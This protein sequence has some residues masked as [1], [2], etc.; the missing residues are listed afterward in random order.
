MVSKG[1]SV[2]QFTQRI[3]ADLKARLIGQ[4][5]LV[6]LGGE[7]IRTK[8]TASTQSIRFSLRTTDRTE[9]KRRQAIAVAFM[10]DL[11]DKLRAAKPV[12][13]T[14]QQVASLLGELHASWAREPD[15]SPQVTVTPA[16]RTIDTDHEHDPELIA[17]W[18]QLH[19]DLAARAATEPLFFAQPQGGQTLQQLAKQQ[20][21][22]KGIPELSERSLGQ[23]TARI[24]TAVSKGLSTA[25]RKRTGDYSPDAALDA[26]PVWEASQ[27]PAMAK[28]AKVTLMG[29]VD[30]WWKEAK[31]A[32]KSES[33]LE[34]YRNSFRHL[35]RFLKHD[36]AA[37]VTAQDIVAFKDHRLTT[38]NPRTGKP[39]SAKTVKASDLTA[40]K[41]V[42]DWA[43]SNLKLPANPASGVNV[44]LGKKVK[45]R[46]RDFTADEIRALLKAANGAL[47]G[48][49]KP[50]QTVQ[51]IRWVPWLCAYTGAR[52]GEL[53]QL[54][55]EDFKLDPETGAWV[56]TIN[57][58]AG[59]VKGKE[60]R[61]VPLHAHLVEMGFM[62]FVEA[63]PNDHLF[64]TVKPGK[65]LLGVWQSK[66]NRLR[67]WAREHVTDPNVAPNHG[68]RHTFKTIGFEAGIQEKVL[69]AICGHAPSSVGRQYGTVS[70]KTKV[71]AME[72]FPRYK[73]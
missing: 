20:G 28:P 17:E 16:N 58:D 50:N 1:S 35:V 14:N 73:L 71:D 56:L 5:L 25:A 33:T 2:P 63:A 38:I 51:A 27:Q 9:A 13:L 23:L 59:T 52:V 30:G 26:Y 44:R 65:S 61:V 6:P 24:P 32:G 42:F 29:L 41:S 46:E 10:L 19:A 39:A 8:I 48:K 21:L 53:V 12:D 66:K 43:V 72:K 11:F 40:F 62:Q 31:A 70:L 45:V 4:T 49:A 7:T 47:K 67:E 55:K 36:D 3:P 57:P 37:R 22:R 34:S 68:W 60:Y 69:D 54:R 64:M 18:D 15:D